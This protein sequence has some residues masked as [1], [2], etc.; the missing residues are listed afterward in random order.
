MAEVKIAERPGYLYEIDFGH[1]I[2]ADQFKIWFRSKVKCSEF[3]RQFSDGKCTGKRQF[4]DE[5]Q[6]LYQEWDSKKDS[7]IVVIKRGLLLWVVEFITNGPGSDMELKFPILDYMTSTS[8]FIAYP[9][10]HPMKLSL[11]EKWSKIFNGHPRG[12]FYIN[13]QK[14]A[15]SELSS[16]PGA[17]A[18]LGTGLG[19][20]EVL[21]ALVDHYVGSCRPAEDIWPLGDKDSN[22]VILV[23]GNAIR[24]EIH[25]RSLS[26]EAARKKGLDSVNHWDVPVDWNNWSSDNRVNI[27]NPVG[28][29][30]SKAA[31]NPAAVKWL[32][33]VKKVLVDEAHKMSSDSYNRLFTNYL[34]N[35][36]SS[37]AI[38]G[39]LDK[40]DNRYLHPSKC[41]PNMLQPA[42]ASVVGFSGAC[43]M[44]RSVA[45]D[46]NVYHIKTDISNKEKYDKLKEWEEKTAREAHFLDKLSCLVDSEKFPSLIAKIWDDLSVRHNDKRASLYVPFYGKESN[47][48]LANK[49]HFDHGLDVCYWAS[50][51]V[52]LNG[53]TIGSS[54]EDVKR[55]AQ[56][57]AFQI[58]MTSSVAFEGADIKGLQAVFTTVGTNNSRTQQPI[59]R[60]ARGSIL[61]IYLVSD[62]HNSLISRQTK[63]RLNRIH[64]I[65]NVK[66]MVTLDWRGKL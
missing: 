46:T 31:T 26:I 38:S 15:F 5:L 51:V 10:D 45:V 64:E 41:T 47:L 66:K 62:K 2:I 59:G 48:E 1:P 11:H 40:H 49:L 30:N 50:G 52:K 33:N 13:A 18:E 21:L 61:E 23:P 63:T 44:R 16:S 34:I 17:S 19:K 58:L 55:L 54:V 39:T 32:R 57:K 29:M 14:S 60:S 28:F 6:P 25:I 22:L 8:P 3:S 4:W 36:I 43:R 65:Y 37:S 12:E 20:T 35:V 7:S 42:N 56:Q 9:S 24:D 27:I 53:E